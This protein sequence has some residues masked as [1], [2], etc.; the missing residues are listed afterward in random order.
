LQPVP[1]GAVGELCIGGAGLARNYLYRPELT[2]EKF[3]PDPFGGEPGA[4]LYKTGDLARYLPDGNIEFLGRLDHQ[5]KIRGFRIELGEIEA[6][7]SQHPGVQD[8]AVLAR[9]DKP[10]DKRLVAYIVPKPE[11]YTSS[12]NIPWAEL[13]DKQVA[14]WETL[15]LETFGKAAE[16]EDPKTNTAGVNSS[17]TNDPLPAVE[18]RDWVEDAASRILSL[19]PKRVLDIGCG[20]GR[21]LFR[22]APSC[23]RYWGTDFSQAALDY[24]EKHLDLLGEKRGEIRL[25]RTRADN[26]REIPKRHFN[27][28]VMNGVI[29]YFPH[30]SHLVKVLEG[31]LD[32]VEPGGVIF[33]GDVR[34]FPLLEAFQLSV[35][36][37][38]ASDDLPTELLWQRVRRNIAQEEE[39]AVDPAFFNAIRHHLA[40]ISH[41]EVLLKRRWAQNELTRFRYDAILHI[42]PQE[43]SSPET[44]WLDW[45]KDKLTLASVRERLLAGE[46][47]AL[48]I[49]RVPNARVLPEVRAAATLVRGDGPKSV[50]ELRNAIEAMRVNA[51]HPEA[52]WTLSNELRYSVDIT[53]SSTGEPEFFDVFFRRPTLNGGRRT[54]ARFLQTAATPAPWR[55][56]AHNPIETKLNRA[57]RSS[58]RSFIEEKLPSHMIPSAFVVLDA[59]PLTP[60]GKLDRR[61][62][63]KPEQTR[64]ELERA[65]VA[66]RTAVE[67]VLARIWA[68]VLGL[69]HLSVHD[70]FFYLGGHSLRATQVISRIR[71]TF[72]VELP[73]RTV[74]EKPTIEKLATALMEN[75][76]ERTEEKEVSRILTELESIPEQTLQH[77]R[78]EENQ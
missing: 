32:A 18:L 46:P 29:Q 69:G 26:F 23:S 30:I 19:E 22:I 15:F 10:G 5:A 64:P 65:F 53:W 52:F 24:V 20:L 45:G 59:L 42:E 60:N 67:E 17:Y 37:H 14:D 71:K 33:V 47:E 4:R 50:C 39:L 44:A 3:I 58:L 35:D 34:S 62:L 63:P 36:L 12:A 66:P 7:L 11:I 21:I 72:H 61:A 77:D 1:I 75:R 57:L 73:L 25:I 70:N 2:A 74:F 56:Y 43:Q 28:V 55:S 27:T 8:S 48:G 9:G 68:E 54:A 31:A 6:V 13:Q 40:R 49:A 41:A 78:L 51:L 38:Q 16:P 76:N